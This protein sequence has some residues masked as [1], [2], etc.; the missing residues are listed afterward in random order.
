MHHQ[1]CPLSTQTTWLQISTGFHKQSHNLEVAV[2]RCLRERLPFPL[3]Q[4]YAST[5]FQ[6]QLHNLD[7]A[8]HG[9]LR[10]SCNS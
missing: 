6:K 1:R 8:V 7:A 3:T 4:V 2:P 9:C 10:E 5:S